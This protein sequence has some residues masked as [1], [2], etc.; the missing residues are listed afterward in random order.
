MV[1]EHVQRGPEYVQR[2]PHPHS[3]CLAGICSAGVYWMPAGIAHLLDGLTGSLSQ[4]VLDTNVLPRE[5]RHGVVRERSAT[6]R[7]AGNVL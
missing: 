4:C 2:A 1:R 6:P 5:P 3:M 7:L